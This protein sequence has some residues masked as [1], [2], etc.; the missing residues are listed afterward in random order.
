MANETE[1]TTSPL[2]LVFLGLGSNVGDR[3]AH[4]RAAL[5]ALE[6]AYHIERLSSVYETAPQLVTD[7]PAFYNLVCAGR[8][9]LPPHDLLRLLKTLEARLGRQSRYRYGPREIDLDILLYSDLVLETADL[10]IPHPRLA[11][12][13]FVL[14]PLA[15]IVPDLLHPVLKR[16]IRELAA[17]V[18]DQPA[19]RLPLV[20]LGQFPGL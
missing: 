9:S 1:H 7:Q 3:L 17:L 6:P 12:R 10:T 18:S 11:E 4:L 5:E 15:E 13:A 19:K 20:V 14:V 2:P 8:T 16:P